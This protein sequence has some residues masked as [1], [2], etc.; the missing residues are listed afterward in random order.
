MRV[1]RTIVPLLLA[2]LAAGL[3]A[4]A[5]SAEEYPPKAPVLTATPG[6]VLAGSTV[7]VN[8]NHYGPNDLVTL[9]VNTDVNAAPA[10]DAVYVP[11][12]YSAVAAVQVQADANGSFTTFLT[13]HTPGLAYITGVGDP[14]GLSATTTVRVLPVGKKG[15]PVTGTSTNYAGLALA[16]SGVAAIGVLLMVLARSRRQRH[17]STR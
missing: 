13:L 7:E 2:A 4:T 10:P 8:G 15:L 17:S 12:A 9:F 16:G 1:V 14:S 11:V 3:P 5:A 6:T